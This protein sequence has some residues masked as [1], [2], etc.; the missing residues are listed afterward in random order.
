MVSAEGEL[1]RKRQGGYRE[2]SIESHSTLNSAPSCLAGNLN[3][4]ALVFAIFCPRLPIWDILDYISSAKSDLARE[5]AILEDVKLRNRVFY[6][7]NLRS[8]FTCHCLIFS[9]EHQ[10]PSRPLTCS[11]CG[12]KYH[13]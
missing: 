4:A 1:R 9:D 8:S 13:A 10:L 3:I 11:Y 5:D 12:V 7:P 2:G 6:L